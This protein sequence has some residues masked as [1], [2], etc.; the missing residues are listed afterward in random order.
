MASKTIERLK[1][2]LLEYRFYFFTMLL[3]LGLLIYETLITEKK[4]N[5]IKKELHLQQVTFERRQK[6]YDQKTKLQQAK[7]ELRIKEINSDK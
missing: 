5:E 4:L 2:L 7:I 3:L 6:E 1:Y